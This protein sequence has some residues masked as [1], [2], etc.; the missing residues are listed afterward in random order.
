M[1]ILVV[2]DNETI[3]E[4]FELYFLE[5]EC[6]MRFVNDGR[7]AF[8]LIVNEKFDLIYM[9]LNMPHWDGVKTIKVLMEMGSKSDIYIMSGDSADSIR[10]QIEDL[11]VVKGVLQKPFSMKQIEE[12]YENKKR[13]M[14]EAE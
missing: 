14:R 10:E 3:S 4:L 13:S 7:K 9:D 12:I 2:D 5:K 8:Q 11:H 1:K 6:E